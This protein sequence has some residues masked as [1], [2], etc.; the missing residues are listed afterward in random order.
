M[1]DKL[2][3]QREFIEKQI[4]ALNKR[5]NKIDMKEAAQCDWCQGCGQMEFE[6][7]SADAWKAWPQQVGTRITKTCDRCYGRGEFCKF[8]LKY[9]GL[10]Q[11][12]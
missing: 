7:Y 5:L 9:V 12:G 1:K 10:C 3:R 8:C 6:E 2:T 11:C 4:K